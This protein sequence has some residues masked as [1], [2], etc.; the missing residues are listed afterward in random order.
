MLRIEVNT[1]KK[2]ERIIFG[3]GKRVKRWRAYYNSFVD[4]ETYLIWYEPIK[5]TV[6][7]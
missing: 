4:K 6:S 7:N 5:E 3:M 1:K 2:A